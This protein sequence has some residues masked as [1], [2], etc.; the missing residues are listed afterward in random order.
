MIAGDTGQII[1][2]EKT[3]EPKK[4]FARVATWPTGDSKEEKYHDLLVS[5]MAN[6]IK[7]IAL[8]SN[9]DTL[10]FSTE[11]NQ[12]MKVNV[13]LD[14]KINESGTKYQYLI[15]P[16]HSR[17]IT[18][19]DCCIKKNLVATCSIDKT[20]RIWN[21]SNPPK[22][23]ICE[24]FQ[25]EAYSVAFH[26]SGYHIIVGFTDKVR[27]MN[28][29][30]EKKLGSV[31]EIP[32]KSCREIQFSNGGHLFACVNQHYIQVYNFYTGENPPNM[33]FN[34]H[35]GKVRCI[36]W[37]EDDSGFVSAG[38]DGK[39]YVWNIK[40]N[41]KPEYYFESKGT[42]FSSV[43]K[44]PNSK[45][46]F[47]VGADKTV[48]EI[49]YKIK[50]EKNE[51]SV[52]AIIS[53]EK[54]SKF[55]IETK[56]KLRFLTHVNYSQ[57]ALLNGGRGLVV[58][59]AEDDRPGMVIIYRLGM[60]RCA[61]IQAHSLPVER[62]KLSF[63]NTILFTAG[64][65]GSFFIFELK[66]P[67]MKK[68]KETPSIQLFEEILTEKSELRELLQAIQHLRSENEQLKQHKQIEQKRVEAEANEKL[69]KL[70]EERDNNKNEADKKKKQLENEISEL[71]RKNKDDIDD[72]M[73][74]NEDELEKRRRD[75]EDKKEQD[76]LRHQEL[77]SKMDEEQRRIS[78]RMAELKEDHKEAIEKLAEDN[79]K[80]LK[81]LAEKAEELSEEIDRMQK[82]NKDVRDKVETMYW[83]E[84][85]EIKQRNKNEL[86]KVTREGMDAKA[87]LTLTTEKYGK[88]RTEKEGF[89]QTIKEKQGQLNNEI[90]K[91][92][93]LKG[94][95]EN[96][97]NEISERKRTIADKETR[98]FQLKKKT[99]ELEKFK[100][101]LDYKIK[102]LKRDINPKEAEIAK[103]NEQTTKMTQELNH[104]RRVNENL[105]LIVDDLKMRQEGLQK[106]IRDQK[107]KL[108]SQEIYIKKFNDDLYDSMKTINN[109]KDLKSSI[110]GLHKKYVL[111]EVR[112]NKGEADLQK[113]YAANRKYL[114]KSVNYLR[115]MITKDSTKHRKEYNNY[116]KENTTLLQEINDLRKQ[117]KELSMLQKRQ[118]H[119]NGSTAGSRFSMGDDRHSK[120]GGD[121]INDERSK[122]LKL[123]DIKIQELSEKLAKL[124]E[125]NARARSSKGA[126]KL[127]PIEGQPEGNEEAKAEDDENEE[128]IR[129]DEPEKRLDDFKDE[130]EPNKDEEGEG[131]NNE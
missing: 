62:L 4:P 122:E 126:R 130:D 98:I 121:Q 66:D 53:T 125:D 113:E 31:K 112:T 80:E 123:Q 65:D 115:L 21:Y 89:E 74:G 19:L 43:A 82:E 102:E 96:Q 129:Q 131:Q 60:E 99:Q 3:D 56:E 20:V 100:F 27:I 118:K 57:V 91:Q 28:V 72:K 34:E 16:F 76:K 78:E 64:K 79:N 6:R 7:C 54:E 107:Q 50:E 25:D 41:Q 103:L 90:Q 85:D 92:A 47:A 14:M 1:V 77:S 2:F 95:I 88:S 38:W 120:H 61:E 81:K 46:V 128:D 75:F 30:S 24:T 69:E 71:D 5:V 29:F 73:R 67:L 49:S 93:T 40:N 84:I 22:L 104:F 13:N 116:M 86:Y 94:E 68:D 39:I 52:S 48:R 124:E 23:E 111:E 45:T 32:I 105:A 127:A 44:M 51:S 97:K 109:Y 8:N 36:S 59:T 17:E 37:F 10:V 58:G 101:V 9:D 18:G 87:E 106:E 70:K 33:I 11:E 12:L 114:E 110:V 42:N 83:N 35:D 55:P 63:D 108:E 15:H 119:V 26:P 117:V